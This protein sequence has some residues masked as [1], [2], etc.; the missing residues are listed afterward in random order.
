MRHDDDYPPFRSGCQLPDRTAK[1]RLGTLRFHQSDDREPVTL[2]PD[3]THEIENELRSA[4]AGVTADRV[5]VIAL[6]ELHAL[7]LFFTATHGYSPSIADFLDG[8]PTGPERERRLRLL[9]LLR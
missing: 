6:E 8:A 5:R 2:P 1:A 3:L 9:K 7:A 4:R